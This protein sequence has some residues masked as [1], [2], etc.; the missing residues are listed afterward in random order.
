MFIYF[1]PITAA[2]PIA[3][4]TLGRYFWIRGWR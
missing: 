1:Y 3:V 4:D 2:V